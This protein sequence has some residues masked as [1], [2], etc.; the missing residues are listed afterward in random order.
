[1]AQGLGVRPSR[2]AVEWFFI[3]KFTYLL[4][5]PSHINFIYL[6]HIWQCALRCNYLVVI[7]LSP[8]CSESTSQYFHWCT[9]VDPSV[10][11]ETVNNHSPFTCYIQFGIYRL[12]YFLLPTLKLSPV[13]EKRS[14]L[15]IILQVWVPNGF[16]QWSNDILCFSVPLL[17]IPNIWFAFLPQLNIQLMSLQNCYIMYLFPKY[18]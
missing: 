11:L 18:K 2:L 1:M 13:A 8:F 17:V 4:T 10:S 7:K 14:E 12:L 16:I 15:H 9:F 5:F 6:S 3:Q